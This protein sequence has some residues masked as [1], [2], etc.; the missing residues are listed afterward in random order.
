MM[1]AC[2]SGSFVLGGDGGRRQVD[3]ISAAVDVPVSSGRVPRLPA[4]GALL[5]GGSR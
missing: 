2:T 3:E 4:M 5:D 1:W